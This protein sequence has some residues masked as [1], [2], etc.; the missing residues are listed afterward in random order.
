M[1]VFNKI[2]ILSTLAVLLI[3]SGC[4]KK[5]RMVNNDPSPLTGSASLKTGWAY[6]KPK[7]GFFNVETDYF[8]KCPQGMV[9]I[10]VATTVR[11]QNSDMLSVAKNNAKKRVASS[12]FYMDMYEVTN[13]EW[14]EYVSWL[15]G[16]YAHRP[17]VVV[18]ALPDET[19][20]RKELA[21]NEPYVRE[22][23][24]S[25]AYNEYP[26][27]GV[28][29]KQATE[30]CKWRTDRLNELELINAGVVPYVPLE[31][32]SLKLQELP[33]SLEKVLFTTKGVRDYVEYINRS[34]EEYAN[35]AGDGLVYSPNFKAFDMN[36]DGELSHNEWKVILEG[37]LYDSEC[38]LPTELEWE[39]AAYGL[40]TE[41]GIY[42]QTN[43]YPWSG[44]QLRTFDKGLEGDF[45]ANFLRGRGDPIGVQIN[46]TLTVPVWT[47]KPNGYGLYN[48]AGN[49]NEWVKDVFRANVAT[50][51]E[52]NTYRGNE[53]E[54]DSMYA[55]EMLNK[56]FA[57]LD[58][59]LRD[60]MRTV[61]IQERGITKTGG[62]Y[63]D[64]KDGDSQSSLNNDSSLIYKDM[65][66]IEEANVISN[67]ARVYKGGGWNDRAIWLNPSQRRWL[68]ENACRNDIGFRC[69]M[70][71]VGGFDKEREYK[72]N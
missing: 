35:E 9:Y 18:R 23:Y 55:E 32:I 7:K 27:V 8:G 44:S 29:W 67:T 57:Y 63:R 39:Y 11:G 30:Y 16:V 64:F 34:Y 22:Y 5:G 70:S 28:S 19:V 53:F 51:E 26:V 66:P 43:T 31:M 65:Q 62:D 33:D 14:R 3:F 45:V 68:D 25:P 13:L 54:T 12:A 56:H 38:R 41:D 36:K 49:V 4:A 42:E 48:M 61:L 72:K 50:N 20:W 17:D 47:F 10:E 69:V 2:V 24:V 60:S 59:A 46:G 15:Q 71:T 1:K 52:I 40:A 58:P 6:N 21:Y 37:A